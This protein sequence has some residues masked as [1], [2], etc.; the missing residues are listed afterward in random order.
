M[1]RPYWIPDNASPDD[2]PPI[3]KALEHPDG[4]LAV[5][6]D[7]TSSRIIMAY[8]LGIFPW[9]SDEEPIL[10]WSPGQ[11]MVLF[12][13]ELYVSRSLRK[14][15]RKNKFTVTLDQNFPEV[16]K[17][18][19]GFRRN[20]DGT[21]ITD[22]MR[23]AYCQLHDYGFAHSV[24]SWYEGSLVGGLYGIALGNVFFGESMFSRVS[25]ASKVA[26]THLVGQLQR[27]GY[28]LIDCQ[29]R[30]A[31]LQSLGAVEIPRQ[32]YRALLD[33]LSEA[34]GYTGEWRF[35]TA[36]SESPLREI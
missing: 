30:T 22:E 15:I 25:D 4:L 34:S 27:W 9:Y 24:E 31:H 18:C 5:G 14:T 2:F 12:P 13:E 21:W 23:E 32:Q 16:I 1:R 17:A 11:R 8:R 28:Q 6:G 10:W 19:A 35:D 7:L 29:V 36:E 26:F 33:C 3:E 20:Q